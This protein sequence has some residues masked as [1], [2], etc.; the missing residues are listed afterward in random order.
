MEEKVLSII[1]I[2]KHK[3]PDPACALHYS[4]DLQNS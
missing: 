2:L 4:K 3:Y 1:E